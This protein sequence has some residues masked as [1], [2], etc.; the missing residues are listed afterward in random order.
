MPEELK[1]IGPLA[2]LTVADELRPYKKLIA[3][4]LCDKDRTVQT[5]FC[6]PEPQS[7]VMAQGYKN[8]I[9]AGPPTYH[10]DLSHQGSNFS[11]HLD[12]ARFEDAYFDTSLAP[13]RKRIVQGF[14]MGQAVADVFAGV[15]PLTVAAAKRG[16]IVFA[17]EPDKH[18]YALL[19]ENRK[20]N[21]VT[22]TQLPHSIP[23]PPSILYPLP[24]IPPNREREGFPLSFP[25]SWNNGHRQLTLVSP[26]TTRLKK[27]SSS[28][29]SHRQD[30]STPLSRRSSAK[31]ST[32]RST[33]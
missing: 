13:E 4:V 27:P 29:Q 6:A 5:V 2:N 22:Q 12:T 11:F 14:G 15:G 23:S 30:S 7:P 18:V 28:S 24:S 16:A 25:A 32:F 17:N 31:P 20:N 1:R 33:K 19:V 8:E 26:Q 9:L 3:E 21:K 10:A